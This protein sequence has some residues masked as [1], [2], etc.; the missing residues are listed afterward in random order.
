LAKRKDDAE[1]GSQHPNE[2]ADNPL[3]VSM[4][5]LKRRGLFG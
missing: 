2:R 3:H 5:L 1:R 4:I